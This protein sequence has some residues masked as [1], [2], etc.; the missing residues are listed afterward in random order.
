M[1][2]EKRIKELEEKLAI[3]E[4][5]PLKEGYLGVLK[6]I[7]TCNRDLNNNPA[8]LRDADDE[9]SFD[10]YNKYILS[11]DAYYNKLKVLRAEMTPAQQEDIKKVATNIFEK[12]L[13]GQGSLD[14]NS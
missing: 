14:E 7:E 4:N 1:S 2:D 8:G 9:K 10:R 3:Y 11:I 13:Q 6:Q 5:S 12:A